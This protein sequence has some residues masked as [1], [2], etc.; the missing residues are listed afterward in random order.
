MKQAFIRSSVAVA[1]LALPLAASA[2]SAAGTNAAPVLGG[3]PSATPGSGAGLLN[4]WLRGQSQSFSP[5]DLGGQFRARLEVKDYFF[6]PGATPIVPGRAQLDFLRNGGDANDT[7]LLTRTR[8]HLGYNADWFHILLE[9]QDSTS[10]GDRRNPTLEAEEPNLQGRV[11]VLLGNSANFPLV[12]K[13]EPPGTDLRRGATDRDGGLEQHWAARLMPSNSATTL[14]NSGVTPFTSYP[15]VPRDN[16]FNFS[17]NYDKLSGLYGSS[18]KLMPWQQSQLLYF[19]A[20][21]TS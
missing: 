1:A 3:P 21:N 10:T 2:Q 12:A 16:D 8:L 17:N 15:V 11:T 9:G 5:W 18:D 20:R 14:R 6:T 19:L 4:D 13:V 7:Y